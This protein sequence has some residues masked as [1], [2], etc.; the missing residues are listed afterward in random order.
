[1]NPDAD[2][3]LALA[4]A[5][6]D[7]SR[8]RG[9]VKLIAFYLPQ[10]H[11][12]PENDRWWGKGFTEW[13]KVSR[14]RPLFEGHYQPHVPNLLGFYD[15][16]LPAVRVQQAELARQ[17]GIFGFCYHYYWFGGVR[18]LERPVREMLESRQPEFPFCICWANEN[19]T[20]RWD[21]GD[22]TI[23]VEQGSSPES[24]QAFIEDL[25][26]MFRD[27]RYIRAGDAPLLV[28]YRPDRLAEPLATTERWRRLCRSAG[29]RE[30]HLVAALTFGLKDPAAIGFD[31]AV[32][33]PPHGQNLAEL[34][35][36]V[37]G[38]HESFTGSVADYP[39][40]ALK[41]I[42]AE[43][44]TVPTYRT[45]M[46]GWDNTARRGLAAAVFHRASP[47]AY[48]AWLHA[49]ANEAR[50]R[51]PPARRFVFVNAWNEWAEGAHLEPDFRFGTAW[52]EATQRALDR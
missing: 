26:P 7:C 49:V 3:S 22:K 44:S 30:L 43:P 24:D 21:G 18:L 35:I 20:R 42:A 10:Y 15:L 2:Q 51:H 16:R 47:F 6:P 48:E 5:A 46:P 1:M 25:I 17:Y 14:A 19:W 40:L 38:L 27:S 39:S 41:R 52:L 11:P 32:E 33:F 13:S 23:L 36:E 12:I 9:D 37:P 29:I 31:A 4:G 34:R 28:V 50:L 45:A 8:S